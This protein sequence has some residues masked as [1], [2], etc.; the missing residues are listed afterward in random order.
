VRKEKSIVHSFNI[1]LL[2]VFFLLESLVVHEQRSLDRPTTRT[3]SRRN[4]SGRWHYRSLFFLVHA[5]GRTKS[6]PSA[7][8]YYYD[9]IVDRVSV[10]FF[11]NPNISQSDDHRWM[12]QSSYHGTL[13]STDSGVVGGRNTLNSCQSLTSHNEYKCPTL[14]HLSGESE[15]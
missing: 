12:A 11:S 9:Y 10:Q 6:Y 13:P 1:L 7:F 5:H 2:Y 15:P 14:V 8:E 4:S 3:G